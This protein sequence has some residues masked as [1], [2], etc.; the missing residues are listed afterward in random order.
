MFFG[1]VLSAPHTLSAWLL[2]HLQAYQRE[3]G[4]TLDRPIMVDDLRVRSA[5]RARPLPHEAGTDAPS[6]WPRLFALQT[7]TSFAHQSNAPPRAC[8]ALTS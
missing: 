1:S 5:G 2:L 3:Y 8:Q 4:F 7:I 6:E